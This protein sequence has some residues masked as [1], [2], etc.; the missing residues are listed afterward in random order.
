MAVHDVR[1]LPRCQLSVVAEEQNVNAVQAKVRGSVDGKA[2]DDLTLLT[3]ANLGFPSADMDVAQGAAVAA[4]TDPLQLV[5]G[6]Y[7]F[8]DVQVRDAVA[9]VHGSVILGA[10][11]FGL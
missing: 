7:G 9:G 3:K 2:W 1:A 6:S 10:V 5:Q 4:F 11:A 8:Y